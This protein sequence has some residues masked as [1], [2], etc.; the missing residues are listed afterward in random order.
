[1]KTVIEKYIRNSIILKKIFNKYL[2][3]SFAVPCYGQ[4]AEDIFL[5]V[6]FKNKQKE[7]Y[8]DI[9]AHH[10][11]RISNTYQLYQ[12]GWSGINVDPLPGCMAEFNERRPLDIN[13]EMGIGKDPGHCIYYSFSEPAYNTINEERALEVI[14]KICNLDKKNRN[15]HRFIEKY[16]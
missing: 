14:K 15:K 11:I 3:L 1:M 6:Y 7:L 2:S 8:V 16:F 9:G 10:P 5:S 12:K 4:N 13:L